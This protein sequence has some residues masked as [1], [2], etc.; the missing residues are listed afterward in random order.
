MK[1][2]LM[3]ALLLSANVVW[4]RRGPIPHERTDTPKLKNTTTGR[5]LYLGDVPK[6]EGNEL[7]ITISKINLT[8]RVT[9]HVNQGRINTY[10]NQL[11]MRWK[12]I[13]DA[14]SDPIFSLHPLVKI[15][16]LAEDKPK[17]TQA[18]AKIAEQYS[19]HILD[20][21]GDIYLEKRNEINYISNQQEDEYAALI[22]EAHFK[23]LF[24]TN[25]RPEDVINDNAKLEQLLSEQ[26]SERLFKKHM[27]HL[28]TTS[29][30]RP[31]YLGYITLVYPIA[32]TVEGPF[33]Q[34]KEMTTDLKTA[35]SIESRWWSNKWQ[36]EFGGFPF[37]LI[38]WSGV[39]FHGPITNY[40][41]L[42]VWYLRRGY[43]SH[44]CHR[45]DSSDILELRAL[46][47]ADL[48]KAANKIK[49]T[50][51]DYFDV[52]DWNRDGTLEA[53]DVKYYNIPGSIAVPKGKTIDE[54]IAPYLVENQKSKFINSNKYAEKF[55]TAAID[56]LKNIPKYEIVGKKLTRNGTHSEVGLYRFDYRPNRIIQYTEIG[57]K[58]MGFDDTFGKYP[59]KYFQKY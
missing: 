51:L 33:D 54:A 46:M 49:V 55:Y 22:S 5:F 11:F 59:P 30:D 39:A 27:G 57:H 45:M 42:D 43:V 35:E 56:K 15:S 40:S 24:D 48:K 12:A 31:G 38:E 34:P 52:V 41:P 26:N 58:L 32:A 25:E 44:G 23:Y 18:W 14:S 13:N 8:A 47:P 20:N 7:E 53:I 28:F 19:S 10:A 6:F 4:S 17:N 36:D 21:H 1:H 2:L 9:A 37:L 29:S 50:V 3:I 16:K